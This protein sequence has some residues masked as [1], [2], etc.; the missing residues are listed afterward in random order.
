M[1]KI[2]TLLRFTI[3]GAIFLFGLFAVGNWSSVKWTV[4]TLALYSI[5]LL[6]Q[7]NR[8]RSVQIYSIWAGCFLLVQSL[9]SPFL[10]GE[11]EFGDDDLITLEPN[12]AITRKIVADGLPGINGVQRF[13][14][15]S[16]GFRVTKNVSYRQ[17][18]T[19]TY[20]IFAIGA[21]T[22]V[23]DLL[24]DEDTWTH[25][26]QETLDQT[27]LDKRFEVINAG[28]S[29][30]RATHH[31]TTL[32]H[33]LKLQ[34]DM[35]IFLVGINDWNRHINSVHGGSK[36]SRLLAVE[37]SKS[38]L[39]KVFSSAY[40]SLTN[41]KGAPTP[42]MDGVQQRGFQA[43]SIETAQNQKPEYGNDAEDAD[44]LRPILESGTYYT[45]QNDSLSRRKDVRSFTPN[46]V[47]P[48]YDD[49][50]NTIADVCV[51]S[52]IACMFITQATGYHADSPQ[53]LKRLFWMTPPNVEYTL[54]FD[55]LVGVAELY[56][57]HLLHVA[58]SRQLLY[59]DLASRMAI[60]TRSFFDDCHFN[61]SG[62]QQA[63]A[64]I[65]RCVTEHLSN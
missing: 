37:F 31:L 15:D 35:A 7:F 29:G 16:L 9:V 53:A 60:S 28:V 11:R 3:G 33:V 14:T 64:H 61:I 56:N 49:T 46:S 41:R 54:D 19:D 13:T 59:C 17:K 36:Q 5:P 44:F 55:S 52:G 45:Q 23:Q 27:L 50:L 24:D 63:A 25:L 30:L 32:Q 4:L 62:A 22:T 2:T 42:I 10:T 43:G 1:T 48:S 47:I 18:P 12:V 21:S 6:G 20:R 58:R 8:S 26:L 39:G 34:P 51:E 40:N 65:S 57:G 38:I